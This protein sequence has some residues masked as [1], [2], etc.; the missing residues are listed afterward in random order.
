MQGLES[1]ETPLPEGLD[2]HLATRPASLEDSGFGKYPTNLSRAPDL[3][4]KNAHPIRSHRCCQPLSGNSPWSAARSSAWPHQ[5]FSPTFWGIS[6]PCFE[7]LHLEAQKTCPQILNLVEMCGFSTKK[8]LSKKTQ[9][10]IP[11]SLGYV[12]LLRFSDANPPFKQLE[13]RQGS[14]QSC[15]IRGRRGLQ[16]I[17]HCSRCFP[18][19]CWSMPNARHM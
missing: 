9:Q 17:T 13:V 16:D 19:G 5:W 12:S 3:N 10:N 1:V 4:S 14:G 15:Q 18:E 2:S 8:T 11:S 6:W 7:T